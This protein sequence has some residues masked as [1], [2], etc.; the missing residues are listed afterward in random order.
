MLS[1]DVAKLSSQKIVQE[2]NHRWSSP[3]CSKEDVTRPVV[4]VGGGT[5]LIPVILVPSTSTSLTITWIQTK[6]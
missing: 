4:E 6:I 5:I 3:H 1:P 2:S